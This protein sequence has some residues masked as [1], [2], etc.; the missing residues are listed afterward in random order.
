MQK[1]ISSFFK[2]VGAAARK[3]NTKDS[4]EKVAVSTAEEKENANDVA[5][6]QK[7]PLS[8]D[9]EQGYADHTFW[10]LYSD[11]V[12]NTAILTHVCPHAMD[13][14]VIGSLTNKKGDKWPPNSRMEIK[15]LP[16]KKRKE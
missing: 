4:Q 8:E 11:I 10:A 2:P 15:G 3:T 12:L 7:R 6:P 16:I 14:S 5:L 9:T 1:Q 13:L